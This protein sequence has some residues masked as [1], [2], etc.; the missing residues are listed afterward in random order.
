MF[1]E[2]KKK[3]VKKFNLSPT[4]KCTEIMFSVNAFACILNKYLINYK[5]DF[6]ITFKMTNMTLESTILWYPSKCW[7]VWF[8]TTQV[9][10]LMISYL[11]MQNVRKYKLQSLTYMPTVPSSKPDENKMFWKGLVKPSWVH[12]TSAVTRSDRRGWT[13]KH[14]L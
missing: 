12:L 1:P 14:T 13:R 8:D 5:M 11:M 4:A 10:F 9:A 3:T 2:K 7:L 6:I